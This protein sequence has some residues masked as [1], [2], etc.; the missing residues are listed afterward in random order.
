MHRVLKPATWAVATYNGLTAATFRGCRQA[1]YR[2]LALDAGIGSGDRVLDLGS[3]PGAL[4]RAAAD[5]AGRSGHVI[6]LDRSP[7]MVI[8]AQRLGG[9]SRVGDVARPPFA[10][11]SFD[12]VVSALALHH[13]EPEDRD[14]VFAEAFRM[15]IPGGRLLVAEFAPPFGRLGRAVA[16]GVFH[17]EIADDPRADLVDRMARAGFQ[18]I[19]TRRSG[20]VTVVRSIRPV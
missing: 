1:A 18:R 10:D 12:V 2:R 8:H 4:T 9:D 16:K 17:T 14:A 11:N 7:E 19:E 20:V 3:G 15:L 5:L 13:V 6:G